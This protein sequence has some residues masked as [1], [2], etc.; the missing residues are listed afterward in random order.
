MT[1]PVQASWIN[2]VRSRL[3]SPPPRRL[4]PSDGRR[5]A[6][7]VPV[8]VEAGQLWTLLT[9]RTDDLPH[10]KSQY[11]FPGGGQELGEDPW[12]AALREAEEEVGI[13]TKKILRLGELDE[14]SASSGYRIIPCVGA[15]PV[16]LETRPN[17]GEI[18]EVFAVPVSAFANPRL[19]EDRMVKIDG[20]ERMIRIYHVGNRRIWG[21][22]AKILKNLVGRLGIAMA[23]DFGQ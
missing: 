7:L 4:A 19:V 11:A 8:F 21:L 14:L 5:A 20:Q 1:T 15:V 18:A 22:T 9:K 23:E 2:E 3:A 10:H 12:A 16:P 6:V 17:P 13:E